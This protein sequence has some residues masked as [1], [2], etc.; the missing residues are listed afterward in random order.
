MK[1]I[2]ILTF[3][4]FP[5]S[6]GVANAARTQALLFRE[7]GYLVDIYTTAT[8]SHPSHSLID[9][10]QV[11]RFNFKGNGSL[12]RRVKGDF[13]GFS[14]ALIAGNYD[15]IFI[16][17]WQT[18]QIK[19]LVKL[20]SRISSKVF[21]VSHGI[22]VNNYFDFKSYLSSLFWIPYK[23]L[24]L[25][26]VFNFI[27]GI[28]FLS[29]KIDKDRFYDALICPEKV[30]KYIISNSIPYSG[31][32]YKPMSNDV[33]KILIVGAYSRLKNEMFLLKTLI[34]CSQACE[35]NFVGLKSNDYAVEMQN[36]YLS[37]QQSFI[38]KGITVKFNYGLCDSDIANLYK[39]SHLVIS[40][41]K[42]ECQ[43]LVIL[44]AMC[45]GIPFIS[46]DVGCVSALPGGFVYSSQNDLIHLLDKLLSKESESI[47]IK[48]S[49]EGFLY[50][51]KNFSSDSYMESYK[52]LLNETL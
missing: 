36:F 4:Y 37:N 43:P 32:N 7:L 26:K 40:T 12:L 1:K 11:N 13:P 50:A 38:E 39:E 47:R 10:F 22:S 2:A 17:C 28:I 29:P 33:A 19:A 34:K 46:S 16:H 51:V 18:W 20:K 21:L 14:N 49:N 41:S 5:D 42:T 27:D 15:Y 3:T 31:N 52:N 25:P 44:Q 6:N 23:Y 9:G 35:V 45:N 30:R 48:L 24:F 8:E